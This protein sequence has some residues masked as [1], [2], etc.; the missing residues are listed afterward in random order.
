MRP[1]LPFKV[2][3]HSRPD[4]FPAQL[5]IQRCETLKANP[6][7]VSWDGVFTMTTK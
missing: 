7:E 1:W 5:Y 3:W 4:D 2:C 6:L